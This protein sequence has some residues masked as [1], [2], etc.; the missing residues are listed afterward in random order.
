MGQYLQTVQPAAGASGF[1]ADYHPPEFPHVFHHK[2]TSER[3]VE[4][5]EG[6]ITRGAHA[7]KNRGGLLPS[8][9][10]QI[11]YDLG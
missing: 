3:G 11:V 4:S 2:R 7:D 8:S 9:Y 6:I 5:F 1:Y 10:G